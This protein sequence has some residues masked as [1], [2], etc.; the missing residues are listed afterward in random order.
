M[1]IMSHDEIKVDVS[2]ET[3]IDDIIDIMQVDF[4]RVNRHISL[5]HHIEQTASRDALME[6]CV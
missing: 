1:D 4:E 3:K 2:D 6:R 5:L